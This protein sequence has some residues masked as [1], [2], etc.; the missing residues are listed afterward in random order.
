MSYAHES[1]PSELP[2]VAGLGPLYIASSAIAALMAA[3]S[4]VSILHAEAIHPDEAARLTQVPVDWLTL[5]VVVPALLGAMWGARRGAWLGLLLWP[6]PL[7][8]AAYYYLANAIG[9]SFGVLF[10]PYAILAGASAY[11]L[12]ALI[13]RIDV[14][15]A[16]ATLDERVPARVAGGIILVLAVLFTVMNVGFVLGAMDGQWAG[17]PD[18]YNVWIVDFAILLPAWLLGGG[19]LIAERPLGLTVGL[20]LL[21]TIWVQLIGPVFVLLYPA[22]RGVGPV[23]WGDVG[24]MA[25]VSLVAGV[26][27]WL[28]MRR[29]RAV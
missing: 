9:V 5:L 21:A 13:A 17:Q 20:A 10:L 12:I 8:Y 3:V 25:I 24:F 23:P 6:A 28:W 11:T 26:P 14:Q 19:L 22:L 2:L 16:G 15:A 18:D 7:F 29:L 27:L 1:E 4:L